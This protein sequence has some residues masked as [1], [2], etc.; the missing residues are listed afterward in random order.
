MRQGVMPEDYRIRRI[1]Q[2]VE[3]DPS[4]SA[5]ELAQQVHLSGSRLGHLFK[6][7]VGVDLDT[8]LRNARLEKGADLLRRTELSI[9]EIAA[10]VGYHHAS[11]FDRGFKAKFEIEPVDYR[12]RH[13]M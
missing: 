1:L 12:R 10:L 8:F 6:L 11:S 2:L 7:E 5:M 4:K 9:K 3:E 13:R